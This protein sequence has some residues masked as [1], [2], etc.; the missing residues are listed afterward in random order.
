MEI[1]ELARRI[2]EGDKSQMD[3]YR[4]MVA[5]ENDTGVLREI[6]DANWQE[7]AI[8]IPAYVRIL[9][10]N[11]EDAEILAALGL[12]KYLIGEDVEALQYLQKA[13]RIR[14]NGLKVMTL[15][16]ALEKRPDEQFKIYQK[17][18]EIDPTNR[19]ALQNLDRL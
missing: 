8:S 3:S 11:P 19:I 12:V 15:Q 2:R 17:M 16:A 10:M 1:I 4:Q 7:D 5:A 9:E 14:P 6:G 18:L 13:K